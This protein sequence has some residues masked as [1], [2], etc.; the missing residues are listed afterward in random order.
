MRFD[1]YL[2][3][4]NSTMVLCFQKSSS[5][6][7]PVAVDLAK[8]ADQ[9]HEE[10]ISGVSIYRAAF[11]KSKLQTAKCMELL[12]YIGGWKS[13]QIFTNGRIV[14]NPY[15]AIEI[16]NCYVDA[17]A[18]DDWKAH[19]FSVKR[20]VIGTSISCD[21][22]KYMFPCSLIAHQYKHDPD[23]PSHPQ[24]RI[25]ALATRRGC[26]WC[27]HFNKENYVR[28]TGK[29]DATVVHLHPAK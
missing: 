23:H 4:E 24:D 5:A 12:R 17:L 3:S 14:Q 27:P 20:D 8:Q 9:Y 21:E 26:D 1:P 19:C 10:A 13:T 16:L 25:Q 11:G 22:F 2:E 6:S 15:S 7:F 18:C 28:I 29:T